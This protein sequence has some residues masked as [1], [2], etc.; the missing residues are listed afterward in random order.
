MHPDVRVHPTA[1]VSSHAKIGP[2]TQIWHQAQIREH[3]DIGSRCI[4][5]KGVYVDAGVIIGNHVKV[6]NYVSIYHGVEIEDGV[7]IGPHV[8][9]TNDN[10]PRAINRDGSLKSGEDW[11]LGHIL[12]KYGAAL[13]ANATLLPKVT[14]GRWAMVGA[15]AVVTRDVPDHGL[16]LGNP[17]RLTGFV[18]ACGHRLFAGEIET[19]IMRAVCRHCDAVVDIPLTLW[20]SIQ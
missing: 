1:D 8:C 19:D 20:R 3:A 13:G 18:C 12:V 15:G 9:F 5:S 4:I 7:F 6:Q 2:G 17:A 14:V 11:E 10:L 16:V